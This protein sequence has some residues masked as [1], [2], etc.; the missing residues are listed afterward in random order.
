MVE[1]LGLTLAQA[2]DAP[3]AVSTPEAPAVGPASP[4][5]P[6]EAAPGAAQGPG[7]PGASPPPRSGFD[8]T[9]FIII[10]MVGVFWFIMMGGQRKEKKKRAAM[11]AALAK[12]AKVQTIGGIL[13][14]VVEVR[15]NEVLVKVDENSNTRMRFAKSAIQA[16]LEEKE[17]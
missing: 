12:G 15:D 6:G 11:L 13:G 7:S 16:V 3:P 4:G 1:F 9:I 8:P 10:L 5:T 14:T 17:D 2:E